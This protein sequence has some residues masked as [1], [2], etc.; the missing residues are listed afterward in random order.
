MEMM[1]QKENQYKRDRRE[2]LRMKYLQQ[3]QQEDECGRHEADDD[4]IDEGGDGSRYGISDGYPLN[5]NSSM[6]M[7]AAASPSSM[8]GRHSKQNPKIVSGEYYSHLPLG[9]HSSSHRKDRSMTTDSRSATASRPQQWQPQQQCHSFE[10]FIANCRH[11]DRL[12]VMNI[13]IDGP[14]GDKNISTLNRMHLRDLYFKQM[15]NVL[16]KRVKLSDSHKVPPI[17]LLYDEFQKLVSKV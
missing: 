15:H 1:E 4:E 3:Q 12:Y 7:E 16:I 5:G 8:N 9:N 14:Y 6:A 13:E 17:D 2:E 11:K 10:E